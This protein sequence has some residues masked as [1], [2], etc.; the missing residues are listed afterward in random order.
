MKS[1]PLRVQL[2]LVAAGYVGVLAIAALLVYERHM[3]YVNHPEEAAAAGG[4]YPGGD[5]IL[6]I[7]IGCMLLVPTFFLVL[8]IRNS[9]ALYT[10]YS[11]SCWA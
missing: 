6:E 1:V 2:L 5:L 8:V 10:R 3:Q 4:M 7:S 9:E 11:R